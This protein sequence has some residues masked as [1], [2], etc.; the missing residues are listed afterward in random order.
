MENN[1]LKKL[2]KEA[3]S[4]VI[5]YTLRRL[6]WPSVQRMQN[7]KTQKQTKYECNL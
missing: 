1:E 2:F 5:N 3:N 6:Q 4:N 7:N